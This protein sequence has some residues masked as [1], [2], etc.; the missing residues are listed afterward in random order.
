[1][2][3][4][5]PITPKKENQFLFGVNLNY[6]LNEPCT[7]SAKEKSQTIKLDVH[8]KLGQ[9]NPDWNPEQLLLGALA[10]CYMSTLNYYLK[11]GNIT[12]DKLLCETIGS[13]ELLNGK[14]RFKKI[15]LYPNIYLSNPKDQQAITEMLIQSQQNCMVANTL[16]TEIVYHHQILNGVNK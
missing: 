13:V 1:M 3:T 10:S 9:H 8:S 15:D 12:I 16:N 5:L 2:N 7:L 6:Q 14:L 11:K 4:T